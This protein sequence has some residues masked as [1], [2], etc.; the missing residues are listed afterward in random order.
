MYPTRADIP[1]APPAEL[2]RWLAMVVAS[3]KALR[4]A[5]AD[6]NLLPDG[7][8]KG[9]IDALAAT[10][11]QTPGMSVEGALGALTY[12]ADKLE[13]LRQRWVEVVE[14]ADDL[15]EMPLRGR[16]DTPL[17]LL[18]AD[19]GAARAWYADAAKE[20][21]EAS[22][23]PEALVATSGTPDLRELADSAGKNA[24]TSAGLADDLDRHKI[25]GSIPADNL[26]RGIRDVE[27]L[28]RQERIELGAAEPRV[29]LLDRLNRAASAAGDYTVFV[30]RAVQ[31][32]ADIVE[33]GF[34]LVHKA[35]ITSSIDGIREASAALEKFLVSKLARK[36]NVEPGKSGAPIIGI[37][38]DYE[39]G[40]DNFATPKVPAQAEGPRFGI[41]KAGRIELRPDPLDLDHADRA[42][43]EQLHPE[44]IR[45]THALVDGMRGSNSH[46]DLVRVATDY[47]DAI[48]RPLSDVRLV[49]L[50]ARGI[51]L[52]NLHDVQSSA[53]DSL[54][55]PLNA[56]QIAAVRN[57]LML[58]GPFVL[59]TSEG[60][61]FLEDA[62]AYQRSREEDF[63]YRERTLKIATALAASNEL[64]EP[65][66]GRFVKEI[67][68][69][70]GVG[71]MPERAR[72][73]ADRANSNLLSLLGIL[74]ISALGAVVKGAVEFSETGQ[75]L[76][77]L[78][79]TLID[80]TAEVGTSVGLAVC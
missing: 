17:A 23:V 59:A 65:E 68:Q 64:A 36:D 55:P 30:A 31:L 75:A 4:E 35:V 77:T 67:N 39:G 69:E 22:P 20:T 42:R 5:L 2:A 8:P 79:A 29:R 28:A 40:P 66:T 63:A 61:Q 53:T 19:V 41:S 14:D 37:Y 49:V 16:I 45:A 46:L 44:L 11:E 34:D 71:R 72:L 7:F 76:S 33:A 50:A 1:V 3:A 9:D 47:F 74:S 80:A 48:N 73:L 56:T 62:S 10:L 60:R 54:E 52:Q 57:V 21:A 38:R 32:G 26:M 6:E 70:V 15:P 18:S 12:A 78:G 25:P 51:Q 13:Q 27:V 24:K 43:L 58:N